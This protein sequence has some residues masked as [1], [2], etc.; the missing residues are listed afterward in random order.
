MTI[1]LGLRALSL[2][3]FVAAATS[4]IIDAAIGAGAVLAI[5]QF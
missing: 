1:T 2:L 4:V 5:G 3:A